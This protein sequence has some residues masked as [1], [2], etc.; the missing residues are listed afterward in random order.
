M[1]N[2]GPPYFY[3][4]NSFQR[5]RSLMQMHRGASGM[6]TL[7]GRLH[8]GLREY[9]FSRIQFHANSRNPAYQVP[10]RRVRTVSG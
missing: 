8:H 2:P 10:V 4:V 7:S 5:E 9:N 1:K 6:P 3:K